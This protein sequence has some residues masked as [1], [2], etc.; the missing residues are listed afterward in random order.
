[1]SDSSAFVPTGF[2]H[3]CAESKA[4]LAVMIVVL[5]LGVAGLAVSVWSWAVERQIERLRGEREVIASRTGSRDFKIDG[6]EI[7]ESLVGRN[8]GNAV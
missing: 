7:P 4:G 5:G 1:M 8:G 3:I 2:A 6:T